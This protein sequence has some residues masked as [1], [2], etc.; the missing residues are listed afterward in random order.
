VKDEET[1]AIGRITEALGVASPP[2]SRPR[3]VGLLGG[4]GRVAREHLLRE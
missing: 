1:A 4:G 2:V 3:L